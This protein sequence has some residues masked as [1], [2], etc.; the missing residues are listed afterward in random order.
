MT[1]DRAISGLFLLLCLIYGYTAFVTMEANLLPFELNMTF[2]PN[3]MPKWLSVLGVIIGLVV[4]VQTGPKA[5][6]EIDEGEI[7]Y[8]NLRQYKLAQAIFLL[9]LMIAYALL[10]RPIGFI[11]ATTLFLAGGGM[12]LG[13]RN[14]K[15]LLPIAIFTAFLIWY[16]VQEL[17]GIFLRP[18][19]WFI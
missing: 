18:W 12:I 1:L 13:E 2:L 8:R 14:Y 7:D 11:A 19:P 5:Q 6:A 3:T 17:L 4:V 16:L 10:L 15:L 9:G